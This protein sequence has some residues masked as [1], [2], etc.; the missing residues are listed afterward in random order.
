MNRSKGFT[1]I[2][3]LVVIAI[4]GILASIIFTSVS[5][6]RDKAK[7]A[8]A[9]G[10]MNAIPAAAE[11]F[12]SSGST[13]V[14]V[15]GDTEVLK[16]Y[17]AAKA[18]TGKNGKCSSAENTYV[19]AVQYVYPTAGSWCLDSTGVRKQITWQQWMT[20]GSVCPP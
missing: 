11:I 2:E 8:A 20:L 4:I 10:N 17:N 16:A 13:Y 7:N 5:S 12:Y 18:A 14:G 15:C 9:K 6:A 1:L 3:L 19:V